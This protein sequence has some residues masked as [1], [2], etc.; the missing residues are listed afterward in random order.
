MFTCQDYELKI[1]IYPYF[2]AYFLSRVQ[3]N[4]LICMKKGALLIKD[5]RYT[6]IWW[7]GISFHM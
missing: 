1:Y 2:S 6:R 4:M 5:F 7:K 3:G